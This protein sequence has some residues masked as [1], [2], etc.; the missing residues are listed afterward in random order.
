MPDLLNYMF[1]NHNPILNIIADQ[2]NQVLGKKVTNLD[3]LNN[4]IKAVK[5]K[6][7]SLP[8]FDLMIFGGI[9]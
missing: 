2:E 5:M 8:K 4:V 6:K 1:F 9:K 3:I 7:V